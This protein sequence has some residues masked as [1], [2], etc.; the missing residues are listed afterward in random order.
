MFDDAAAIVEDDAPAI[1]A[2]QLQAAFPQ[3]AGRLDPDQ[4]CGTCTQF[5]A[6]DGVC[7]SSG[8]WRN[9]VVMAASPSCEWYDP[10]P[11]GEEADLWAGF[12]RR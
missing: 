2:Q 10:V 12:G 6:R 3:W 5:N 9:H 11:V 1:E 4:R 8:P 7:Q